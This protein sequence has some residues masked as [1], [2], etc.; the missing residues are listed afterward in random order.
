MFE[1]RIIYITLRLYIYIIYIYNMINDINWT[2]FSIFDVLLTVHLS[3]FFSVF[4]QIDAQ[5]F[6]L[7]KFCASIWLITEII[8]FNVL[9]LLF[10]Q[11]CIHK[12]SLLRFGF[13]KVLKFYCNIFICIR[14]VLINP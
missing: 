11:Y 5:N 1:S 14:G 4:K 2:N 3:I 13:L 7:Q 8:F 10:N 6:V 12:Y 9:Y